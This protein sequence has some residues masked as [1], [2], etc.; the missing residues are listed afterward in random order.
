VKSAGISCIIGLSMS[1][2]RIYASYDVDHDQDLSD[3]LLA[4]SQKGGSEFK[5]VACSQP[6]EMNERWSESARR[7]IEKADEVILICGEHTGSSAR[8]SAELSIAREAK[9]PY[10]MLWGRRE[11]MCTKPVGARTDEGIYGWTR[12][13]L[14]AQIRVTLRSAS[15]LEVPERYKRP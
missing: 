4:Q 3:R 6:G 13:I 14:H 8:M 11:R 12:E 5:V 10:F 9:K 7:Q 1:G 2:T 15:P